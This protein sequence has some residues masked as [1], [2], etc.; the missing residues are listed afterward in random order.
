M[1][2]TTAILFLSAAISVA[3]TPIDPAPVAIDAR[4]NDLGRIEYPGVSE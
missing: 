4:D 1:Q 2:I 3:A